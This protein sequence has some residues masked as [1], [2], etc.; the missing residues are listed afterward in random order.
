MICDTTEISFFNIKTCD[1]GLSV[2]QYLSIDDR[3][4][5]LLIY[6][7][8]TFPSPYVVLFFEFLISYLPILVSI[9]KKLG[10]RK[11]CQR[12]PFLAKRQGG[13]LF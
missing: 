6:A 11:V 4:L 7:Q 5:V 1:V 2:G 10:S 9:H 8:L 3:P 12:K 13:I